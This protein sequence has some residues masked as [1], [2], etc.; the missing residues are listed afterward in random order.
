MRQALE[1]STTTAPA[2]AAM[3]PNS[4]LMEPPAENR[5]ISMPA[6]ESLVRTSTGI[7]FP[8]KV[9]VLPNDRSEARGLNSRHREIAF[10]QTGHHLLAHRA[11]GPRHRYSLY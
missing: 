10:L 11:G 5:A 8:L 7:S 6:K 3:G 9:T 1:L 4:L 2:W